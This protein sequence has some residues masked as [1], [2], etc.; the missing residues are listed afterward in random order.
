M[1]IVGAT[2]A[3]AMTAGSVALP[4]PDLSTEPALPVERLFSEAMPSLHSVICLTSRSFEV[5]A[6]LDAAIHASILR[7]FEPLYDL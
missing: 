3:T 1:D 5:T 6:E 7:S 2:L 4:V